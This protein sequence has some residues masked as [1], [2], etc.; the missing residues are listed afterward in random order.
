MLFV[1]FTYL[2]I[3]LSLDTS[4]AMNVEKYNLLLLF[5]QN[6]TTIIVHIYYY[7]F[8]NVIILLT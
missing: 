6:N 4:L 7:N 5:R 8:N 2:N 3:G 1:A